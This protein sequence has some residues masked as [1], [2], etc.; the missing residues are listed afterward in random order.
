MFDISEEEMLEKRDFYLNTIKHL[1]FKSLDDITSHDI[2]QTKKLLIMT[3]EELK[4]IHDDLGN[5]LRQNIS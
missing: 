1:E 3:F 4:K 5:S 2:N